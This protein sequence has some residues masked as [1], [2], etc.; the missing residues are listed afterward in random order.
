[1]GGSILASLGT[2]KTL[3]VLRADYLADGAALV[4][5]FF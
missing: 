1:M 3:W 2:F 4:N 5:R